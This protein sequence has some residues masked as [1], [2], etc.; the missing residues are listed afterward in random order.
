MSRAFDAI[1]NLFPREM[2]PLA[3]ARA[4]SLRSGPRCGRID[5]SLPEWPRPALNRPHRVNAASSRLRIKIDT[6]PIC[7]FGE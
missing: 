7:V 2:V 5:I 3:R 4:L 1:F 6:V